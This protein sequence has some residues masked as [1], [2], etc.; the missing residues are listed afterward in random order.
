MRSRSRGGREEAAAALSG[1]GWA[2]VCFRNLPIEVDAD[3]QARL[4]PGATD[5]FAVET[6]LR[7]RMSKDSA[8]MA[9]LLER[10]D[11][12]RR[13]DVN[14]VT[15]VP[16]DLAMELRPLL[17]LVEQGCPPDLAVRIAAPLDWQPGV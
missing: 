11:T 14:R 12:V 16:G 17:D 5:P 7:T 10:V 15:Q 6:P 2:T 9:E 13:L 4:K 3:G 1:Y 8:R